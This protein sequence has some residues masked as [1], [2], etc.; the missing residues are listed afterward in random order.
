MLQKTL[1]LIKPDGVVRRLVGE[2]VERLERKGFRIAGMR[3]LKVDEGL[4][5]R[6]YAEHEGK[7]FFPLLIDYITSGPIIALCLEGNDAIQSL[8]NIVGNTNPT[9]AAAGTIRGD[10]ALTI[11]RNLIHAADSPEAA[12]R[13]IRL[14]FNESDI[15]SHQP[16]L[17][18]W[19]HRD[20]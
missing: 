20:D 7:P 12:E 5:R 3:M 18:Q 13:E 1:C 16:V 17:H 2:L 4:A 15:I 19:I 11:G 9:K 8:R 14:F 6:H 10:L